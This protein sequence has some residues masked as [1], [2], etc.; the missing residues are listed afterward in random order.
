MKILASGEKTIL[1]GSVLWVFVAVI[2]VVVGGAS[3]H[4]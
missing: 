3:W 1:L 2:L 4:S